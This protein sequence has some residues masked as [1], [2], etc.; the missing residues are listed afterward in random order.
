MQ[1]LNANILS[2][3]QLDLESVE[4][5][6]RAARELEPIAQKK[7]TSDLLRGR[8]FAA[9]FYEPS[10]RTR[11]SF[12]TA[13]NRLGGRVISVV[14]M[15]NSSLKKG[16]TLE[17]TAR[18][19][20]NYA[21]VI[22]MRHPESGSVE[23]FS[24]GAG[25]PLINAGDGANEHPT[26]ALTD[27]FTME[28]EKGG[29]NGLTIAMVG[30]LK[31]GRTVHSLSYLLSHF[32]VKLVFVAPNGLRM[33]EAVTAYL[34]EKGVYFE[35]TENLEEAIKKS[36]VLY[37]TRI[38]KERFA[39]EAEYRRYH[40]VY[41]LTKGV[42]ERCNPNIVVLHPLPRYGEISPEIDG[43]AG[44]AY[45]RQAGNAVAVRMGLMALLLGKM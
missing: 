44:A 6:M 29:V 9:L 35:E 43:L 39:T 20:S 21:D 30:D 17:D 40:G 27:I 1:F 19:I 12:E 28:K 37:M 16:E 41:I 22:A 2:A 7:L 25:V 26:Q 23:E 32:S 10:T 42:V 33:P 14:G 38:Q 34:R 3:R 8:V 24:R 4:K 13:M 45:F 31:Y 36:D 15:E 18:I 11:L 5:I